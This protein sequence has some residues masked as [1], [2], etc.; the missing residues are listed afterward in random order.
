MVSAPPTVDLPRCLFSYCN[1]ATTSH[2]RTGF[3]AQPTALDTATA[4]KPILGGWQMNL[5]ATQN[6]LRSFQTWPAPQDYWLDMVEHS[7][8][9]RWIYSPRQ[10]GSGLAIFIIFMVLLNAVPR[11]CTS[12]TTKDWRLLGLRSGPRPNENLLA[13]QAMQSMHYYC[14]H[15]GKTII[16]ISQIT[17]FIGGINHSQM[18]GHYHHPAAKLHLDPRKD[19]SASRTG[20]LR[21]VAPR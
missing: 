13:P 17:I 8:Q 11:L 1:R 2:C 15:V 18:G 19:P 20:N 14:I 16:T 3:P 21:L 9:I 7:K 12:T 5:A 4:D 6:D 10:L